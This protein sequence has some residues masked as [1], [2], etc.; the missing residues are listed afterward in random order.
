MEEGT[1]VVI[2]F[3]MTRSQRLLMFD[4]IDLPLFAVK[5]A[6]SAAWVECNLEYLPGSRK[7][8]SVWTVCVE[9]DKEQ[10]AGR[11]CPNQLCVCVRARLYAWMR[12]YLGCLCLPS[13]GS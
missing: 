11:P 9:G 13:Q 12:S 2:D 10:E 1:G 6:L 3:K 4:R 5:C 8:R 7:V